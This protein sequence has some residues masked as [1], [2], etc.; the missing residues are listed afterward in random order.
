VNTDFTLRPGTTTDHP[1]IYSST[2]KSLRSS[3]YYADV[4]P[5]RGA[6]S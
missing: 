4:P 2:A 5:D 1:L 6:T 3:P